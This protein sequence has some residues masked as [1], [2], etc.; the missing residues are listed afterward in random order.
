MSQHALELLEAFESLPPGERQEFAVEVLRRT[1]ELPFESC[2]L[3]DDEIGEAGKSLFGY[4]DREED[5]S[6]QR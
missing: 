3:S 4:W 6:S 2:P 1:R 5:P